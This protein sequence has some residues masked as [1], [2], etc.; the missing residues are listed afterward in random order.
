[1]NEL[2][3]ITEEQVYQW[4]RA[5]PEF[6]RDHSD[7]LPSAITASGRV[8]SLENG[9]LD[10]LQRQNDL[11]REQLDGMLERIRR[12]EEIYHTFHTVQMGVIGARDLVTLVKAATAALERAFDISRV[13]LAFSD[14]QDGFG[15][16]WESR[17][18][19]LDDRVFIVSQAI[20]DPLMGTADA[21]VIRIGN[22]GSSH[23]QHFFGTHAPAIRSEALVPLCLQ[24]DGSRQLMGSLNM[25]GTVPSR[26][27]PSYSTDLV[28]DLSDV[29]A[30]CLQKIVP[31]AA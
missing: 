8:L 11:I 30:L 17:P 13:T 29:I 27:I 31:P 12:N 28:Q 10:H 4:L 26:F 15:V 3:A 19:E 5:H 23:R 22:E 2:S 9:K 24:I 21:A 6:F 18:E 25:G 14:R 1:M 16:A 7:L 20:L